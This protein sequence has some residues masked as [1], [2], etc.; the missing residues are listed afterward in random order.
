MLKTH[1][2]EFLPLLE[3]LMLE[4]REKEQE[5]CPKD[6]EIYENLSLKN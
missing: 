4:N 2:F 6:L 5:I 3:V 1:I